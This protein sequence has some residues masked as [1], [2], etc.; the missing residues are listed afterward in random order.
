MINLLCSKGQGETGRRP[1][2]GKESTGWWCGLSLDPLG[3][4]QDICLV[5]SRGWLREKRFSERQIRGWG[6]DSGGVQKKSV[7]SEI[8]T[9]GQG[10]DIYQVP[11]LQVYQIVTIRITRSDI[12]GFLL[13]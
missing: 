8:A 1:V 12:Y 3:Y 4:R 2:P 5:P 6:I 9:H 10:S 7:G 11:Y 13:L